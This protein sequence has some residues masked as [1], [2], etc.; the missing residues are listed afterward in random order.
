MQLARVTATV[1]LGATLATLAW[2]APPLSGAIFTTTEDGS[3]VNENVRYEDKEDVYLDGGPGPNAPASAAGLPEGDYYFQVTDPSGKDLL[4]TDHISCR[5]V[6]VNE[7]G[8][9]DDYYTDGTN[10]ELVTTTTGK[11]KKAV[12]TY[13][14]VETACTGHLTGT[15]QDHGGAPENAITV[16]LY[17]Y[18]DTPNNGGVY[19]VW[20]IPTADYE[21]NV[22]SIVDPTTDCAGSATCAVNG[23]DWHGGYFHGFIGSDS[24]TDNFKV[25][26]KGKP[27]DAATISVSKFIDTDGDGVLDDGESTTHW[28]VF[29]IDDLGVEDALYTPFVVAAAEAGTWTFT[30]DTVPGWEQ[31]ALIVDGTSL[32]VASSVDIEVDGDC[33]E[34]HTVVFGNRETPDDGTCPVDTSHP[35]G[36][37][38]A[39]NVFVIGDYDGENS[40]VG[41]HTAV[42]G[43]GTFSS[44]GFG[45]ALSAPA[46]DVLSVG[47]ALTFTNGQIYA[48][49]GRVAGTCSTT[50]VGTPDGS[51]SCNDAGTYDASSAEGGLQDLADFLSDLAANGSVSATS[52]GDVTLTGTDSHL[53]VFD[54]DLDAV[55]S[56][57]SVGV[58]TITGLTIDVPADSTTVVNVRG[59]LAVLFRNGQTNLSGATA[60][61]VL[62]NFGT[63]TSLTI[64]GVGVKGSVLAPWADVSFDN[65]HIDGTLVAGSLAGNGESHRFLFDG[66]VCE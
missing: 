64:S 48:G 10:Y 41:G 66:D 21:E 17:P 45:T 22:G 61:D 14:W 6:H 58:T 57:F 5:R 42:G 26:K 11:G 33:G 13:E 39:Y 19:K 63:A 59:N 29:T 31:T 34:T 7:Y 60:N 3:I 36:D 38:S 15:D 27:C 9:I 62:Y 65:G 47:G 4:S 30:E 23:E 1:A 56:G 43:N 44:F 54:L 53:N 24:K 20:I 32:S 52:W 46:G 2:A 25:E 37:A 35:L 28:K 8:V 50:N 18:D 40:D 49:D 51:L 55:E 12:T 16:Q